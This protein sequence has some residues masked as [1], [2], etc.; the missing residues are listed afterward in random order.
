MIK[1]WFLMGCYALL[2]ITISVGCNKKDETQSSATEN[3]NSEVMVATEITEY[4]EKEV[5]KLHTILRTFLHHI[6]NGGNPFKSVPSAKLSGAEI[7]ISGNSMSFEIDKLLEF[8]EE[9]WKHDSFSKTAVT[10]TLL[11]NTKKGYTIT[12]NQYRPDIHRIAWSDFQNGEDVFQAHDKSP[13]IKTIQEQLNKKGYILAE[14]GC[15][16]PGKETEFFGPRTWEAVK[17]F[18]KET[19]SLVVRGTIDAGTL[20]ELFKDSGKTLKII[21]PTS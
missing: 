14:E 3:R 7:V 17:K 11:H 1:K 8:E 20:R 9:R 10:I 2:A 4:G 5:E 12:V 18:Q 13:T 21:V 15:G 16:S 6:E 19:P